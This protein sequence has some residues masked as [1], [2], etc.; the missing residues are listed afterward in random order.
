M[1]GL[2]PVRCKTAL[3]FLKLPSIDIISSNSNR[4]YEGFGKT[5]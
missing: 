4:A 2:L 5:K 1:L 3:Y